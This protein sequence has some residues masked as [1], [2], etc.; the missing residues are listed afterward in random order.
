MPL[1]IAKQDALRGWT[2]VAYSGCVICKTVH[3][4]RFDF[5]RVAPT[6]CGVIGPRQV[7]G[8]LPWC[9]R[10]KTN[11]HKHV[12]CDL[13][14]GE[15][16]AVNWSESHPY[17]QGASGAKPKV[18]EKIRRE[19]KTPDE[20]DRLAAVLAEI[21]SRPPLSPR[22]L[23][24]LY[25]RHFNASQPVCEFCRDTAR[26]LVPRCDEYGPDFDRRLRC[27]REQR[28]RGN[29]IHCNPDLAAHAVATWERFDPHARSWKPP[30]RDLAVGYEFAG[31]LEPCQ[32]LGVTVDD[33]R[34]PR[35]PPASGRGISPWRRGYG[36]VAIARQA[37]QLAST[38]GGWERGW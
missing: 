33:C 13:L 36:Q 12:F 10:K 23:A 27:S 8:S 32:L 4:A 24:E 3:G 5:D 9:T 16:V 1:R 21:F 31:C 17:S 28:H 29:H 7:D 14:A 11:H 25:A 35:I 38:R 37:A 6:W 26:G 18:Y 15:H 19:T 34:E 30:V 22:E 2:G 20:C